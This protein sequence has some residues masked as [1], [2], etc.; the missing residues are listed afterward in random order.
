MELI[1]VNGTTKS[2]PINH[3]VLTNELKNLSDN[4]KD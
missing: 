1:A 4:E 2:W 3:S